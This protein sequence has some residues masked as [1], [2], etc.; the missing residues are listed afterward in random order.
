MNVS[1]Y[2]RASKIGV[3]MPRSGITTLLN[4]YQIW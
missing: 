3:V 1:V 4:A 2:L